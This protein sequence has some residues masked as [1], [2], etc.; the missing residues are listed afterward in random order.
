MAKEYRFWQM[1]RR[2]FADKLADEQRM[3]TDSASAEAQVADLDGQIKQ[4]RGC[5]LL[6]SVQFQHVWKEE[7]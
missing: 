2:L 6:L 5:G 4:V 7:S 3:V 1:E